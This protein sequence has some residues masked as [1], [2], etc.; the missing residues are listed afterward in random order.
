MPAR[1]LV[2][3][4][5]LSI[6]VALP[7]VAHQQTSTPRIDHR[8]SVQEHRIQHGLR[9]GQLTPRE[10]MRLE[11]SAARI[12]ALERH[13]KA[14]GVVTP[15]ERR[16]INRALDRQSRHIARQMHDAQSGRSMRGSQLREDGPMRYGQP[17]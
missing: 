4:M 2:L 5:L 12:E 15:H 8:Q 9:T 3:A 10:A 11:R 1:N 6:G 16:M 13:A 7:A 17:G 14:D